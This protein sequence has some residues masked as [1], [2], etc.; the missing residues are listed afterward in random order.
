MSPT[1]RVLSYG[2]LTHDLLARDEQGT[3]FASTPVEAV[4]VPVV[5]LLRELQ[6]FPSS[7]EVQYS[8]E[9]Q[10]HECIVLLIGAAIASVFSYWRKRNDRDRLIKAST[11]KAARKFVPDWLSNWMGSATAK[12]IQTSNRG[13]QDADQ[14]SLDLS[15]PDAANLADSNSDVIA[16]RPVSLALPPHPLAIHDPYDRYDRY[17]AVRPKPIGVSFG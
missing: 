6:L 10:T 2:P 13:A 7:N 11:P 1:I 3:Q 17:P 14:D 5:I 16:L 12:P 8:Q 15:K 9:I 4:V